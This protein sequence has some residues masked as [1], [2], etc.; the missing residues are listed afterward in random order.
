MAQ[1]FDIRIQD[2]FGQLFY[3]KANDEIELPFESEYDITLINNSNRLAVGVIYIDGLNVSRSGYIIPARSFVTIKRHIDEDRAF[4]FVPLNSKDAHKAGKYGNNSNKINGLIEVRFFLEKP[5]IYNDILRS[6]WISNYQPS[7]LITYNC[8]ADG[9]TVGG[10]YTGQQFIEQSIDTENDYTSIK[11]FL[12]GSTNQNN[13]Q[14]K[15]QIGNVVIDSKTYK[16]CI[17]TTVHVFNSDN[18][19]NGITLDGKTT[20]IINPK[21]VAKNIEEYY[22]DCRSNDY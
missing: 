6:C 10:G 15:I 5:S 1:Q 19:Y 20:T 22:K 13:Q 12:R 7:P 8:S 3:R 16:T 18:I 2:K 14:P 4:K 21:F 17:V 9:C 11:V